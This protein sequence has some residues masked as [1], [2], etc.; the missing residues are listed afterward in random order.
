M[1]QRVANFTMPSSTLLLLCT[2][3]QREEKRNTATQ[4]GPPL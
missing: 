2:R 3:D 1:V 4:P